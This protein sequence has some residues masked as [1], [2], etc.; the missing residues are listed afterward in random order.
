LTSFGTTATATATATA[1]VTVTVTAIDSKEITMKSFN[2]FIASAFTAAM[3]TLSLPVW[4][5]AAPSPT[6]EMTQ[7]EIRKIDKDNKKITLKHGEIKN[8]DMPPMTM[9]FQIKD[10]AALDKLKAGDRVRFAAEK[11]NAGFVVTQ[12][13]AAP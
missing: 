5:Q 2:P 3:T 13:E 1:T 7:G 4:A 6:S 9:V 10:M 8:L 11:T 12:I